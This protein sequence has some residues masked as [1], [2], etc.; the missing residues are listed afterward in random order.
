MSI[1]GA[2]E[3]LISDA[4]DT[5]MAGPRALAIVP[6]APGEYVRGVPDPGSA[7]TVIGC[8]DFNPREISAKGKEKFDGF[9]PD[10]SGDRAHVSFDIG[11]LAVETTDRAFPDP[12][13][14]PKQGW[15][16]VLIERSPI[17]TLQVATAPEDDGFGRF[18]CRCRE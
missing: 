4:I 5:Y 1:F 7:I 3:Q 10:F 9:Q 8:V 11:A 17:V 6:M 16:L 13:T 18:V 14:W 2:Y 12:S 15:Q